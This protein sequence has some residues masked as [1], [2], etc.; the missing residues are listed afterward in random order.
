[1]PSA[2][3]GPQ[4]AIAFGSRQLV[5]P[6]GPPMAGTDVVVFESLYN[7][8][9]H[10]LTEPLGADLAVDGTFGPLD[11]AAARRIQGRFGLGADGIV[12][13]STCFVLG[14]GAGAHRTYG[15]PAFGSRVLRPGDDGGDVWVLQNRLA[16][17][18][19]MKRPGDG[20]WGDDTAAAL[21]GW[22]ADVG[23]AGDPV[24]DLQTANALVMASLA[25]GRAVWSGRNGLDVAWIQRRLVD[26]GLLRAPVDGICSPA[27]VAALRA[28]QA[29]ARLVADGVAGPD[30][31]LA[32]GRAG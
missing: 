13:P 30:T 9:G 3:G 28:F 10:L 7:A 12:G 1:M 25:G 29:G 20:V 19:R 14:H 5:S 32:L 23:L 21:V 22:K 8:L 27:T 15:G 2:A 6:S 26:A 24:A 31:F 18:G 11:A 17:L 16:A 4:R